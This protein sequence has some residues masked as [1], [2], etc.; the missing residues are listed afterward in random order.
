MSLYDMKLVTPASALTC[1][2]VNCHPSQWRAGLEGCYNVIRHIRCLANN[3]SCEH[4]G[5]MYTMVC[6]SSATSNSNQ[7]LQRPLLTTQTPYVRTYVGHCTLTII[8]ALTAN[9]T[10]HVPLTS[11]GTRRCQQLVLCDLRVKRL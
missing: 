3:S 5:D 8:A 6:R 2:V 11:G 4:R 9:T 10:M 1:A 7:L